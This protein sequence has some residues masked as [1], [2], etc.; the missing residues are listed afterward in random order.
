[1]GKIKNV[2]NTFI[3]D[4]NT[5]KHTK[6]IIKVLFESVRVHKNELEK[7]RKASI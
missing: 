2:K 3:K 7:R 1:M 5:D 6:E 4:N